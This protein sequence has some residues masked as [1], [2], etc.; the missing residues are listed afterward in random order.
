MSTKQISKYID[1]E[2][3]PGLQTYIANAHN[4][5]PV[6]ASHTGSPA[7]FLPAGFGAWDITVHPFKGDFVRPS[8][9]VP[10]WNVRPTDIGQGYMACECEYPNRKGTR[11]IYSQH[12]KA[13][14]S[15]IDFEPNS[16]P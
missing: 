2:R 12:L 4:P 14:E 6:E 5:S 9:N 8:V 1:N 11:T 7:T 3:E 13:I 15:T 10:V 16:L